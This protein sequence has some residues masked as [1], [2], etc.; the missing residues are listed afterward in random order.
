MGDKMMDDRWKQG[1]N[2]GTK[3]RI[4]KDESGAN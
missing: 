1:R 4:R 2:K 3:R